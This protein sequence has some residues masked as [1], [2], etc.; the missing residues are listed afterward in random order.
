MEELTHFILHP[1]ADGKV[2]N[3]MNFYAP[4][5]DKD[6]TYEYVIF[7]QIFM[8]K[9]DGTWVLVAEETDLDNEDQTVSVTGSDIP[10]TGSVLIY[11]L[12]GVMLMCIAAFGVLFIVKMVS[13][14]N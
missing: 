13:K 7:E 11:V 4:K 2:S 9:A 3:E 8:E 1:Q 10:K 6:K 14:S 12:L 5:V